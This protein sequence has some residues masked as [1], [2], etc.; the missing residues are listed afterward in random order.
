MKKLTQHNNVLEYFLKESLCNWFHPQFY[1][2]KIFI[3]LYSMIFISI[4]Q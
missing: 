2:R 1:Y 4:F 3:M